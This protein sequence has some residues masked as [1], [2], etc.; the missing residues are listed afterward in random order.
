M[1]IDEPEVKHLDSALSFF[2]EISSSL[3]TRSSRFGFRG[4]S[5]QSWELAPT[6]SRYKRVLS[7]RYP[8]S[9][10]PFSFNSNVTA[11]LIDSF[12]ENLT[13]NSDLSH[14]DI[15]RMDLWQFG[16]HYGLPT[17]LLDWT[18]SP[19][20]ALFFAITSGDGFDKKRSVWV[21]DLDL[22]K[23]VN[24]FIQHDIY[25]K[26][27]DALEL[28]KYSFPLVH[29]ISA[30]E[31]YNKRLAYQQGFFTNHGDYYSFENWAAAVSENLIHNDFDK[32][33]FTKYVF[34]CS[35]S[36]Q[37]K[38]LDM[39][40]AM[41]INYRTLFP[42]IHGSVMGALDSTTRSFQEEGRTYRVGAKRRRG[43]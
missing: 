8:K 14:E 24:D 34:P 26:N 39:L 21:I 18:Y 4:Q 31:K 10:L 41:N 28:I 11:R 9:I 12:R 2:N 1:R 15:N 5:D 19:Y 40:D 13:I 43:K 23:S 30:V 20:V 35:P 17:P 38:V 36:E 6:L 33:L 7:K 42:D 16:Q 37:M 22:L 29:P 3:V 25:T 27:P 32:P